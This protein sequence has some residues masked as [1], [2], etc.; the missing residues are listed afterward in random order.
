MKS[1]TLKY[2]AFVLILILGIVLRVWGLERDSPSVDIYPDE[3]TWTDEGVL[4]TPAR[5]A[6]LGSGAPSSAVSLP[7]VA[8]PLYESALAQTFRLFGVGRL[9]GRWLSVVV[10]LV[11]LI[12]LALLGKHVWAETGALLALACGAIGFFNVVL[13]RSIMLEGSLVTLLSVI[14]LV[15]LRSRSPW[16]AFVTGAALAAVVVG[17]KLHAL[18]LAPALIVLYAMRRRNALA[19]FLLGMGV[20]LIL[21][22]F[23][24]TPLVPG[25]AGYLETRLTEPYMGLANP[26]EVIVHLVFA[27]L[28]GY[29]FP[30]QIALLFFA[31]LEVVGLLLSP[32][33]WLR[34]VSDVTLVA[35]CWLAVAL[36]GP[37]LF[38]YMPARYFAP[39]LAPIFLLA[40]A[41]MRRAWQGAPIPSSSRRARLWTSVGL[42]FF[43]LFQIAPPLPIFGDAA[44]WIPILGLP[45]PIIFFWVTT[46]TAP[47]WGWSARAR[48]ILVSVLLLFHFVF[49]TALFAI[50]F[51]SNGSDLAKAAT[52]LAA[53]EPKPVIVGRLAESLALFAPLDA[54]SIYSS[55]SL[56]QLEQLA[57]TR[58]VLVL[59]LAEDENLIAPS[60][61]PHLAHPRVFPIHYSSKSPWLTVYQ[62][63]PSG[64]K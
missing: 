21:W 44:R 24:W 11:G 3:A 23:F 10:G 20:V 22:R 53:V 61:R 12:A 14:A 27:G 48:A 46:R 6:A 36:A 43:F 63:D 37:S 28:G 35:V 26:L 4:A 62:F 51:G 34:E 8:H 32:R 16:G 19:P 1:Q 9:Q 64:V 41:G 17:I 31:M 56:V 49:Q 25:Y 47:G 38:R 55:I 60:A 45:A 52:A 5:I 13:D 2:A 50:G 15:G 42:G 54:T 58:S 59:V 33:Q 40:I 18:A 7:M 30:Y 29:F 57:Q 39:A